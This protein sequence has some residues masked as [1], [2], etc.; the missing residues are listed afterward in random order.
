MLTSSRSPSAKTNIKTECSDSLP[1][2]T[3]P[4]PLYSRLGYPFVFPTLFVFWQ[5]PHR[6]HVISLLKP[7][8]VLRPCKWRATG[9]CR[10][11]VL[12]WCD[13][14]YSPKKTH[15]NDI[16]D[17]ILKTPHTKAQAV[18]LLV[19]RPPLPH[20]QSPTSILHTRT[21]VC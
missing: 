17:D 18:D 9:G 10:L 5:H 15:T 20:L 2:C 16:A 14:K 8:C 12:I 3:P 6:L 21:S 13:R 7:V 4:T 19:K 11:R 1:T